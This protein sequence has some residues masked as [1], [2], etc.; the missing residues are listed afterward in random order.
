MEKKIKFDDRVRRSVNP[1]NRIKVR[2]SSGPIPLYKSSKKA[3]FINLSRAFLAFLFAVALF[4]TV[5]SAAP[6]LDQ[7]HLNIQTTDGSGNVVTGTF[8]FAFNISN[9]SDCSPVIYSNLTALTTDSRGIISY[10]LENTN[11]DYDHQY[12]LCYY[13]D[14]S[15]IETSKIARTPYS[16]TSQNVTTSGIIVDSNLNLGGYNLTATY[17]VGDGR[18]L[19]NLNVSALNLSDYVPYTGSDKNVVLGDYNFSVGTSDLFV[20]SNTG[21][22]GVGT[23]SPS[24]P[25]DIVYSDN[26]YNA[27]VSVMN[28]NAGTTAL[29]GFN[30]KNSS[31][32]A[33][34]QFLYVSPNYANPALSDTFLIN[35]VYSD[36]KLG[37]VSSSA[38]ETGADIYFQT[39]S[40]SKRLYI[41]G[42]T[43]NVG[44]GTTAPTYKLHVAG[45]MSTFG[46]TSLGSGALFVDNNTGNVGI[47]TT[48]PGQVLDVIGAIQSS[49][50]ASNP[51]G[52]GMYLRKSRGILGSET[53]VNSGDKTGQLLFLGYDGTSYISNAQIEARV[54]GTPG[55]TDMPGSLLFSTTPDGSNTLAERM[56]I[57]SSGNVGIGTTIPQTTLHVNGSAVFNGTLN[58]DSNKIISL[59]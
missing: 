20:N 5:V 2:D 10:Y 39:G 30:I 34:G 13:R 52:A 7:L 11:L 45:N 48:A 23:T 3:N 31:G 36:T 4:G 1:T 42:S 19:T 17:F 54:D 49:K 22:I 6:I 26:N 43:G 40:G 46:N 9:E 57:D 12:Y 56:R 53:I 15:L 29:S 8:N 32:T 37:F 24:S 27:G 55:T 41:V 18:Y 58:L 59:G 33:M 38:F 25:L 47:G 16:F 28:S 50:I 21:N 35:S 51:S 44:I 14:G